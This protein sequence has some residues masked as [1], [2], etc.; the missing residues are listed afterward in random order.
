MKQHK[1]MAY[2]YICFLLFLFTLL[3]EDSR[4]NKFTQSQVQLCVF[5]QL[6]YC[7]MCMCIKQKLMLG[8]NAVASISTA[9]YATK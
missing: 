4:H 3:C 8:I 2:R 7:S 1:Y 5:V 6:F 9:V